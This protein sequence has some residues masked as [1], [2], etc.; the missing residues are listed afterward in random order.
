MKANLQEEFDTEQQKV[1][2]SIRISRV[3]LPILLGVGA[4][5]Y[6]LWRQF[7]PEDFNEI[8]DWTTEMTLWVVLAVVL[9]VIR[10]LA[11]ALRLRT[12]SDKQFTWKK[13]I[14][15]IFIWEFSTAVSP[16]SVGGS[17]VSLF[18]LSQEKLS[19]AK[20]ATIVIYAIILDTIFFITTLPILFLIFGPEIIRPGLETISDFDG[21]G[22]SFLV[23]YV[24]MFCYGSLFFY[25]LFINPAATKKM[26]VGLTSWGWF[27]RFRE[28]AV[29]MG[30]EFILASK[31][32]KQKKW[33]YHITAFLSTAAAWS[34][35]FFLLNCLIIAFV[36]GTSLDFMYQM[37]LYSRL[38]TMFVVMAVVPT[39]GGAGMAELAFWSFT[40]DYIPKE[41]I[42]LIVAT[43]W[44]LLTYYMYL[45]V[46]VIVIPNW[47]RKI[48]NKRRLAKEAAADKD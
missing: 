44:R 41:G 31:E 4:V 29:Q 24:I 35:R 33:P 48:M 47:I 21:W 36:P 10:H 22:Y 17:A 38:E 26:I 19:G 2:E 23:A 34:C 20:T 3:I 28:K 6:L 7:N 39:P 9:L 18:V 40:M 45:F 11:Y 27:K 32:V 5:A 25:G 8:R 30:D 13:C 42:A 46:G 43:L 1:L 37:A 15:L 14:E 12:L 16:T